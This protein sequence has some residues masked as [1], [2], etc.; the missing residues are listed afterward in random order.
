MN[1]NWIYFL[2]LYT[3][4]VI[5]WTSAVLDIHYSEKSEDSWGIN[6][7]IANWIALLMIS[8]LSAICGFLRSL[9]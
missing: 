6:W 9:N 7:V 4:Y 5:I 2:P 1:N 8:L 3:I